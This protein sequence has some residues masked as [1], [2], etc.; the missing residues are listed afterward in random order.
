LSGLLLCS[1]PVVADI[2]DDVR[3]REIAFSQSVEM[4]DVTAFRSFIDPDDR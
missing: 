2:E 3:C 1:A 4:Q